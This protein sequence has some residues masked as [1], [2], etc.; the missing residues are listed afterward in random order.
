MVKQENLRKRQLKRQQWKDT[1][2]TDEIQLNHLP[3]AIV[4]KA[5]TVLSQLEHGQEYWQLAGKRLKVMREVIRIPI[6]YRYRLLCHDDGDRLTPIKV[7]SH[8]TYNNLYGNAKRLISSV[9][10]KRSNSK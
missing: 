1:F 7:V 9:F 10:A 8:E 6:T 3:S 2:A 4:K 5:R